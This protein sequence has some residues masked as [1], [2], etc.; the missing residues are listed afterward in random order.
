[1]ILETILFTA[2][3]TARRGN[4]L[5]ASVLISPQLGGEEGNPKRLPLSRYVDFRGGQWAQIVRDINWELTL[6]WSVDD[7]QED[8]LGAERVSDDPDPELFATLFPS[9]M[10]VDPFVFRNPADAA[11]VSYPAA[12]LAGDLDRMQVAV[13]RRSPE[14]RPRL[15]DLVSR[16]PDDRTTTE[17]APLNGFVL[18]E[19][20]REKYALEIDQI[21]ATSGVL[22]TPGPGAE[23][24]A[25]SLAMLEEMLRPSTLV[26]TQSKPRWPELDFHQVVSL[27]QSHPNLLRRLGLLVDLRIPITRIRNNTGNPRVYAM[28]DWP[29]P[30]DPDALGLDITTA[31]PRVRTTL[32][33][34]YFRPTPRSGDLSDT[35]YVDMGSVAAITSTLESEAVGTAVDATGTARIWAKDLETFGTPDRRGVPARHSAGVE[36]VRPDEARRWK[37]RMAAAAALH[38]TIATGEDLFLDAEDVLMG[39]RVDVRRVGEGTWHSLHRRRGVLTPYVG[40]NPQSPLDLGDDEGWSE[41]AASANPEDET[42]GEFTKIRIR[43]ALAQWDGWSLSLPLP[44]EALDSEDQPSPETTAEEGKDLIASLHGT[45][46]YAAPAKGAKLPT[47]RFSK[48]EYEARM[49]WVDVGGNSVE[50]EAGGGSIL[51]FPY[52]RH[53]P[54]N[55]PDLYLTAEPQWS[56]SVEVMVLR[57]GNTASSNRKSTKRW[58][59]P[60]RAAAF[61]CLMHGVFDDAQG[62]PQTGMY[63]TIARRE[64][65]EIATT[66]TGIDNVVYAASDPGA[67]PYLPDPL[68][69]GLLVRGLPKR[70][71]VYDRELSLSYRGSWPSVE[72][73]SIEARAG[74]ANSASVRGDGLTV[75]LEPGRVAHLRLSHSLKGDGLQLMDLWRRIR[76]FGNEAKAR[77]GAYW[78]LTPDRTVVVVHAVQRP[79]SAPEFVKNP[80]TKRWRSRRGANETAAELKG[81]LTVDAPSTESVDIIGRRTY[82]V[83]EGPGTERPRVIVNQEI[84][85]LGTVAIPDPAPGGGEQRIDNLSV[86]AAFND[87]TRQQV[88]LTALGKSRFAEYFRTTKTASA[89]AGEVTLN[90]GQPVV[91]GSARVTYTTFDSNF[92]PVT[93][94]AADSAF[95][96]DA[97]TGVLTVLTDADARIPDNA[98]MTISYIPGPTTKSSEDSSVPSALRRAGIT[99]PSAARP[100]AP[101]AEWIMPAFT[102]SGPTG[103]Q[104]TSQRGGGWL[105]IYLARPWF[106]SG[107]GEELG[108]V[109]QPANSGRNDAR[110]ALVTQWALDPITTGGQLP[111]GS[112]QFPKATHFDSRQVARN[113]K[114]VEMDA[115]VDVVRYR[116]GGNN[117]QG[118]ISGFDVDRDMYFVDIN[119][120]FAD[121][122]R[123][124]VRLALARYQP[125]SVGDLNLSPV[126]LV[127]VVQLEPDRTATVAVSGS[128]AKATA[129]VTLSG[130]S[131]VRNDAGA[132]PGKA[133]AI[134]ERYDGPT[135]PK[136]SPSAS[137]AWTQLQT[138]V[139]SGRVQGNGSATWTGRLAVP[140]SR[141]NGRYRIVFEQ[142]ELIRSD[143]N[144]GAAGKTVGERLV[145]Q[146]IVVI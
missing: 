88:T 127:D 43:E 103:N 142:F 143:G 47:L 106:S 122:Y 78:M 136:V 120:E 28:V 36:F 55:A 87:T 63:A 102:W 124:F 74:R 66:P 80:L 25:R 73:A 123:P 82:A 134:L 35:G 65:E 26:E 17:K 52:L 33:A 62:R 42:L 12:R 79:V 48:T 30:Y 70:G 107:I 93:Q 132:G 39:Y 18:D 97:D 90:G 9:D 105:R 129:S 15:D 69:T 38:D 20:R 8:Y 114:L 3:P 61:F 117:A 119:I 133:V 144:A 54:V 41:L 111:G 104:R 2:L 131:Y 96:L 121:A 71:A 89:S 72:V 116:I 75:D 77:K 118:V 14:E 1:M 6:R 83:D 45:I 92:Q 109:L 57:S 11:I 24:T 76:S 44:G 23:G 59:A 19:G 58:I 16:N 46:D 86:R 108:I 4:D 51:K 99:V 22:T 53:D 94:T 146:D 141:P 32:G 64:N 137:A 113:V 60:Q 91:P 138:V 49:R 135:G 128:G 7:R 21:L 112:R 68:A 31:F 101:V 110:D 84:G 145:H 50:P 98:V 140:G 37:E 126:A 13:A 130:K 10:P 81:S 115:E 29:P 34:S 100:L 56:E 40:L 5:F 125:S 85:V 139:L 27:L 67:V 95:S